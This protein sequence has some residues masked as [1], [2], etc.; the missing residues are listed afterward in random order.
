MAINCRFCI[1]K[2]W[3]HVT[4]YDF[5]PK[6]DQGLSVH[7]DLLVRLDRVV[8]LGNP[9]AL[10]PMEVLD[11]QDQEE[12]SEVP[13]ILDQM[14]SPV[15]QDRLVREVHLDSRDR[16]E[17]LEPLVHLVLLGSQVIAASRALLVQQVHQAD[18]ISL[19][20]EVTQEAQDRLV[21]RD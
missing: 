17:V 4:V 20:K 14:A 1:T 9:E 21:H 2:Q 3:L 19:E 12:T 10:D 6:V 15:H 5:L 13:E 18:Q 8:Y 7:Q 16:R 11:N